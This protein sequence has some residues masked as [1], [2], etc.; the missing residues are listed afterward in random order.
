MEPLDIKKSAEFTKEQS[1]QVECVQLKMLDAS[2][3]AYH[4]LQDGVLACGKDV[5]CHVEEWY[6]EQKAR[7]LCAV[8]RKFIAMWN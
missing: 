1:R 6:S 5:S 4:S 7:G 2:L 8:G 3:L